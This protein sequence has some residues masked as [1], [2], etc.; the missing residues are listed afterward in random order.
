LFRAVG[1]EEPPPVD[2]RPDAREQA[3]RAPLQVL[4]GNYQRLKGVCPW[5]DS[6]VAKQ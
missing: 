3:V 2:L 4:D 5:W 1:G 6:V